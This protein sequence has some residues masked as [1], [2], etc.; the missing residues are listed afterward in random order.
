[1]LGDQLKVMFQT[2]SMADAARNMTP[3]A[4]LAT[5]AYSLAFGNLTQLDAGERT[6]FGREAVRFGQ[7]YSPTQVAGR[8]WYT[9][10]AMDRLVWD[11]L[12][13]MVD[14]DAGGAFSRIEQ[15]ARKQTGTQYWWRPGQTEPSRPPDLG[16]ALGR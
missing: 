10:L 11:T 5:N 15:R 6:N 3:M 4:G 16:A 8:L 13:R 14:P 12:Q 7:Q 2:Q 1:M 9:R